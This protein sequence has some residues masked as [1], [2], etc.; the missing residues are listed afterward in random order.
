MSTELWIAL[1]GLLTT[2]IGSIRWLLHVYFK[3]SGE[4]EDLRLRTQ[5]QAITSIETVVDDL[6]RQIIAHRYDM[7]KMQ[8][9]LLAIQGAVAKNT[10]EGQVLLKSMHDYID[11]TIARMGRLE[12][13]IVELSKRLIMVKG[14]NGPTNK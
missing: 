4:I 12:T 6:K 1:I 9:R 5:R 10:G 2:A 7:D 13:Q 14:S 8:E 3:Q 11:T